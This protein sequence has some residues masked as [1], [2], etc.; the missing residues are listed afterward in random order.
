MAL[1]GS[2]TGSICSEHYTL[3]G[4]WSGKQSI[5]G[6]YTDIKLSGYLDADWSLYVS[7]RSDASS[8]INGDSAKFTTPSISKSSNG[9][10][11]TYT[12]LSSRTVRVYH[13]SNGEK[14]INISLKYPIR[15]TI[16]GT[17]Y[18][19]ITASVKVTLDTIPRYL[20]INA[21]SIQ[22]KTVNSVVVKWATSDQ[23]DNTQ[24]IL[25][26]GSEV[27]S[28]TY[29]ENVASDNKSGTFNIKNL[30]PNKTYKLKIRIRRTDSQLWTTSSEIS[31]T[32]YDIAKLTE[33]PDVNIESAHT[34]K[35]T[36][37]SGATISLKLCKTDGTTL[38]YNV[39]TVTGT[40]KSVT[41]KASTIYA[42]IPNANSIKLRYIITTTANDKSYTN[43]KDCT[44][45]VTNSNPIFSGFTYQDTN[46]T[47]IALTGN[48]QII[49]NSYSNV[50]ATI[51]TANK[52]T[53][54][55]SA[56]MKS[57]KLTCG[58]KNISK[59]YS[60]SADVELLINKVDSSTITVYATDSRGNSTQKSKTA[61][62]KNY[63][64][65]AI[66]KLTATRQQNGVGS[67]VLL[68]FE[69]TYWNN[70]FG[71]VT[72]AISR[73]IYQ[74]KL[75]SSNTWITGATQL[76]YS[77]S[78][79]KFSGSVLIN[80]DLG[81]DG[82]NISNAYNIRLQMADK[83]V[84]KAVD[85]TLPSGAPGLAIAKEGLAI[86]QKYNKDLG[87]AL[88]VNGKIYALD[89][90]TGNFIDIVKKI[91]ELTQN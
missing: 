41:P 64:D 91:K 73:C 24:Y 51:S 63:S 78:D 38:V 39:G 3:R 65:L 29:G 43:Y 23:R 58:T 67:A 2:F 36:N 57:Y 16:N 86:K 52:A 88:Q 13:D 48:N 47:T 12:L 18:E 8:S 7:S 49:I 87:G 32:T 15:A 11:S 45:K 27:G 79:G 19:N 34:I 20:S 54:K 70:S 77:A 37:P 84:T 83:L 9:I 22:S 6:N 69:G 25:D 26:D 44:F 14:T 61:T 85:I 60:G 46:A 68:K 62:Y 74:Y 82:F 40:S 66:T 90:E 76:S 42:L 89:S 35:W 53:A 56:T 21:F 28:T 71:A 59:D 30:T 75:A 5:S 33:T 4:V 10:S 1:S 72:N 17:Y 55:N 50:K 80:G 31:F 81:A